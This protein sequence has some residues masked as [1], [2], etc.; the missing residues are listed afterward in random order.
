MLIYFRNNKTYS[1][2]TYYELSTKSYLNIPFFN[3]LNNE[4]S[5]N[6]QKI[7]TGIEYVQ[8]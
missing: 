6:K 4:T 5:L 2:L 1:D 7:H 3:I 8:L